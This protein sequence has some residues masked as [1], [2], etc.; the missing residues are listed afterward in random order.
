M[1]FMFRISEPFSCN[2]YSEYLYECEQDPRPQ[3]KSDYDKGEQRIWVFDR[4]YSR[5]DYKEI[6]IT[7]LD[8]YLLQRFGEVKKGMLQKNP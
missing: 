6:S 5:Q 2:G 1:R 7:P 4:F 8:E 3:M